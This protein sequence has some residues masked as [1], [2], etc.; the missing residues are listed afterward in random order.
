MQS[1]YLSKG[2]VV[3]ST[4]SNCRLYKGETCFGGKSKLNVPLGKSDSDIEKE[5]QDLLQSEKYKYSACKD[6]LV[7]VVCTFKMDICKY[8]WETKRVEPH[9]PCRE[10]CTEI[11]DTICYKELSP[12]SK[13]KK[14]L[15]NKLQCDT[16]PKRKDDV[17]CTVIEL[18]RS[19]YNVFSRF[20]EFRIMKVQILIEFIA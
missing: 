10:T 13:I 16:F 8:E 12:N 18:G 15:E 17:L 1:L 3:Q 2:A 5:V 4:S 9:K 6:Y 20:Q 14:W 11:K 7:K 19:Q